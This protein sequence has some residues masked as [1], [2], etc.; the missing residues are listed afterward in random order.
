MKKI[1]TLEKKDCSGCMACMN[2][3]PKNA[4]IMKED[5]NGFKY[6]EIDEKLCIDCGLC[7]KACPVINKLKENLYN[8]KVYACKNKDENIR[9]KSSSGGLFTL[10]AKYILDQEGV[11][12]GAKYDEN[13]RV[14][15]DYIEK[16][17]NINEF[18]GSKYVQSD[19]N[20]TYAKAKKFL[21]NGR[22]VLFTGTPCQIEGLITYLGKNYSNLYTQDFIC[23]G[24]PSPKVWKKYLDYK[25]EKCGEDPIK[26]NFRDKEVLGWSNFQ[27]KYKYKSKDEIVHHDDDYYMNFFL[28]NYDLRESCY[29][30]HF[31]KIH[32][33]SD[34]T[35]ADFWGIN[36]I[37]PEFN[38]EKGISS[39]IINSNKG[40][41]IFDNI[42]SRI[43][44]V[45]VNI[46]DIIKHNSPLYVSVPYNEKREKFFDYLDNYNFEDIIN[47]FLENK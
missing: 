15:H 35:I 7:S 20:S 8:I 1:D 21:S 16:D 32:R 34:L 33:N 10:F 5:K 18:R 29:N 11:V 44:F 31:K 42:K 3:C 25:K 37:L 40:Q 47:E 2:I 22:K 19:I 30:C 36:E 26:V 39:L 38:D 46:E 4:I 24:V 41:E 23:H 12:F 28:R 9:K 43:D 17:D 6:P 14:I 45:E 27:V 13:L